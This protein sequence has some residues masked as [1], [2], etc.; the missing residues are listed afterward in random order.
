MQSHRR[1][2]PITSRNFSMLK[3]GGCKVMQIRLSPFKTWKPLIDRVTDL[4]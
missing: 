2:V 1:H 4:L 3:V